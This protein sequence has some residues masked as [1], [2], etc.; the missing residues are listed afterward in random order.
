[1]AATTTAGTVSDD[2][3]DDFGGIGAPGTTSFPV[4]IPTGT[5]MFRVALFDG[6]SDGADDLDLYVYQGTTLVGSSGGST[7][8][9]RVTFTIN[10][11]SAPIPLTVVVHGF[12]TDGPNSNF[13]LFTWNVGTTAAGNM[14]VAA[15]ATAT[16]G[17]TGQIGL[18]FSGLAAHTHY[19]GTVRLS[20]H[21]DRPATSPTV[22][23]VNTP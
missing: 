10:P 11:A 3:G 16:Q 1:M 20:R 23:S 19:L 15:P 12:E 14:V 6:E 9:E 13:T 4:V 5:T 2:P 21:G 7:S 22:V 18:T 17:A 8:A